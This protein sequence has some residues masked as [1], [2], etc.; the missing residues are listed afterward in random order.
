MTTQADKQN[1]EGET[2]AGD[3][4]CALGRFFYARRALRANGDVVGRTRRPFVGLFCGMCLMIGV[5]LMT[6]FYGAQLNAAVQLALIIGAFVAGG[7]MATVSVAL[8]LIIPQM[9]FRRLNSVPSMRGD[10][11]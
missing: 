9:R 8:G 1:H 2:P 6:V 5:P 3:C 7:L 10:S 11:R 4:R